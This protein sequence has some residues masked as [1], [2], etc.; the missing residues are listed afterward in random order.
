MQ[1]GAYEMDIQ[2]NTTVA[3]DHESHQ[4][5]PAYLCLDADSLMNSGKGKL[6]VT[7]YTARAKACTVDPEQ[8]HRVAA[9]YHEITGEE[10]PILNTESWGEMPGVTVYRYDV[11]VHD[12]KNGAKTNAL[13]QA[14]AEVW[15]PAP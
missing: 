10:L 1:I 2:T 7:G 13:S 12:G 9:R 11:R 15:E 3:F 6:V 14:F 5:D 8:M 4:W